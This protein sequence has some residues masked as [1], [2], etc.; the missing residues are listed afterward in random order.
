[1]SEAVSRRKSTLEPIEIS[2]PSDLENQVSRIFHAPRERVFR[3]FTD[4]ATLPVVWSP[5]PSRV[6]VE[7][8]DFRTG[9]R[10]AIRVRGEDGTSTRFS[11]EFLEFVP[12][13]RVVNT[14]MADTS[15]GSMAV[16]TDE[17]ESVGEDTR[18]TIRW[19]FQRREDRDQMAGPRMEAAITAMWNRVAEILDEGGP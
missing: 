7:S 5:D 9:G 4:P 2:Q 12:P 15:P 17:F 6:T 19:K 18:V 16:E 10:F 14:F 11:G 13:R 3:L 8:V 1:M